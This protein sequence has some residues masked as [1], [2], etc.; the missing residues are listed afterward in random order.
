[1]VVS[2]AQQAI[3]RYVQGDPNGSVLG[4]NGD[5]A[6]NS[7]T[8]KMWINTSPGGTG[9]VWAEVGAASVVGGSPLM[10][11]THSTAI[12]AGQLAFLFPSG[13]FGNIVNE[14]YAQFP[15]PR[16]GVARNL[17]V[18]SAA[19]GLDQPTPVRVRKGG[20]DTPV[21]ATV[22]AGS[23]GVFSDIVNSQPFNAG[24]L[25]SLSGD[26]QLSAFGTLRCSAV[27]EYV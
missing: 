15:M 27:L 21:V 1:M 6:I 19:N 18:Y 23:S 20:V 12:F 11:S 16:A 24:E 2:E 25:L 4:Q 3:I 22:P 9:M 7:S 8:G 10:F 5:I 17:Y 14:P 26:A 13:A